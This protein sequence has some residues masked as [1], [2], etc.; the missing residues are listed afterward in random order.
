[1]DFEPRKFACEVLSE[2]I[3]YRRERRWLVFSWASSILIGL[4]GGIFALA[5]STGVDLSIFQR[6]MLS[7]AATTVTLCA[8]LW[9]R[10]GAIFQ[11]A[12]QAALDEL[13][14][15]FGMPRLKHSPATTIGARSTLCILLLG[16]LATIWLQ[17]G[18]PPADKQ[19]P[20]A[21]ATPK[22]S[23]PR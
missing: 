7:V 18:Q 16:A 1:M 14:T 22:P 5:N 6:I 8:V 12:E 2:S 10:R 17:P 23:S 13:Y 19:P 3:K 21:A 15:D 20:A 9:I 4:I 11:V